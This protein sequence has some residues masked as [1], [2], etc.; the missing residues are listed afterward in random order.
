MTMMKLSLLLLLG[1]FVLAS[2]SEAFSVLPLFSI[3]SGEH[4]KQFADKWVALAA[5]AKEMK[6]DPKKKDPSGVTV[7]SRM[8]QEIRVEALYFWFGCVHGSLITNQFLSH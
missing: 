5:R 3:S 1:C 4:T 7:G 2:V 8:I 6:K